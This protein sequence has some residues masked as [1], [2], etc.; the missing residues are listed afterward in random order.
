[1]F[2]LLAFLFRFWEVAWYV[3]GF[4]YGEQGF[5]SS[6]LFSRIYSLWFCSL[7]IRIFGKLRWNNKL[8]LNCE[9]YKKNAL[10]LVG[11][12]YQTWLLGR[13]V[14]KDYK[15]D[16]ASLHIMFRI[17][18]HKWKRL[19][20]ILTRIRIKSE[21]SWWVLLIEFRKRTPQTKEPLIQRSKFTETFDNLA[22]KGED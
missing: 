15:N 6:L 12:S 7:Q 17:K 9:V 1:M 16:N 14:L 21:M 3:R 2:L 4:F 8:F 18:A 19:I 22:H 10:F 11:L 20:E 13:Y 5:G